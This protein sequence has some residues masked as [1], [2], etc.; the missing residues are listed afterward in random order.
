MPTIGIL[1]LQGCCVPHERKFAALGVATRR[2]LYPA[3]LEAV[4]GLVMPG[5]ESTTMLKTAT[6]GLWDAVRA[7]AARRPV[8][9]ICAGC[10]LLATGV[11][12]PT[13]FSL[14]LMDLDVVRNGYGAQNESFITKLTVRLG[15]A[16]GEHEC[17]FIRAPVIS[18]VGVGLE[19]LAEQGGNP[20]MVASPRHLATTFHPELAAGDAFHRFFVARVAAGE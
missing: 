17:V 16:P 20:V 11:S 12:H 5:G 14:A 6:P 2:I 8:W 18:R 15:T 9:G 4:Q 13:Q 1:G 3:D 7:F 10:I 19:V